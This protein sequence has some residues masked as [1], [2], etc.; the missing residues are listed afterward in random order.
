MYSNSII[1][2]P[3]GI[4]LKNESKGSEMV[5]ILT[6]LHKYVPYKEFTREVQLGGRCN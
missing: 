5:D 1:K 2:V 3:L 4:L 6:H